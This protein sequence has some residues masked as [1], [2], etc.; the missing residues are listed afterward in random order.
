MDSRWRWGF[1]GARVAPVGGCLSRRQS[2]LGNIGDELIRKP[3]IKDSNGMRRL[4]VMQ[5]SGGDNE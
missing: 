3:N 2:Q 1:L 4:T 5:N